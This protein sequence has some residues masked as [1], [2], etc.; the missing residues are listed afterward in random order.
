MSTD[1]SPE[2][3]EKMRALCRKI[4]VAHDL[5]EE[6]HLELYSHMEDRMRGYIS[7]EEKLTEEDAFILIRNHFSDPESVIYFPH[8]THDK[9][10]NIPFVRLLGAVTAVYLATGVLCWVYVLFLE[11]FFSRG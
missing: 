7:S 9:K 1:I 8:E 10:K 11:V 2:S 4:S 3:A 5:D 6:I